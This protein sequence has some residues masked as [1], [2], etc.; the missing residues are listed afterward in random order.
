MKSETS[1]VEKATE[2]DEPVL[3]TKT[4]VYRLCSI[5]SRT[6][7][8]LWHRLRVEG[9][10]NL[11]REGGA[12]LACNH[13]SF[14]DILILGG[15]VPRHTAFVARDTLAHWRWLAYVMRECGT[16]LVKRGTSD[17]RALRG[18][19]DHLVLGD[20]V[21]IF[22]EGTRSMDGRLGEMKG[23]ALLAARMA[24]V[25]IVPLGIRGA[26]EAW[27]KGRAIPFPKKIALRF[28]PAIDSAREDAHE[29]MVESIRGMIGDG[30]Y[31]SVAP[32]R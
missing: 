24:K 32:T 17:R 2:A 31:R 4:L 16:V 25:P 15:Y 28:G 5:G 9:L 21:A 20:C 27:P 10:E 8:R 30:T 1:T 14:I 11:P 22:P 13:Q 6:Y 19:A 26:W 29:A 18:M 3:V 12:V 7:C 23:G